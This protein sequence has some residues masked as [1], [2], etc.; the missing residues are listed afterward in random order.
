MM[1]QRHCLF[2]I[3]TIL[4]STTSMA[5]AQTAASKPLRE[6]RVLYVG[7]ERAESYV[8]F[9][10][11]HVEKIEAVSRSEFQPKQA[12]SFDVVLLDWPQGEETLE[13]HK[14][15]SPLGARVDWNRPTVLL[16]SA[17]LNL[18]VAWKLQ[19]GAGCTCMDPIAYGFRDH[20]IFR[21]PKKIQLD[22]QIRIP[23]P[24]AFKVDLSE[25][26]VDVL[27]L[28]DEYKKSWNAGW[29][30]Y[31]NYFDKNP[32]VEF[33]CGGVN[34]KTPTA[35]GL[36]RQGNLLHFGFEQSPQEMNA[37]GRDLLLNSIAYISRFSQD[38][39]IAI[40]PSVFGGEVAKPRR[41]PGAWLKYENRTKWVL[42]I[43]QPEARK[44][45]ESFET[46]EAMM[47]W[48]N[49]NSKYFAPGPD[50]LLGIDEDLKAIG[51]AFD[52]PE[53]FEHVIGDLNSNDSKVIERSRR[54]LG[55][56]V[57]CGPG[58]QADS[59]EWQSWYVT[60]QPYLFG[61]DTGDYQWYVDE[62]AK[63]RSK[64]SADFRGPLRA[65]Q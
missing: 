57:P 1:F 34:H 9:L 65:D 14:L 43:F 53:F 19:G 26:E 35:A 25:K 38:R 21:H 8:S 7:N 24:E 46:R 37:H 58:F 27:P 50:R 64:P 47:D 22:A 30:T 44:V 36:W 45:L 41:T 5:V 11:E 63:S 32:D 33:F 20:E 28:V 52:A 40:T 51:C 56:Y 23:T 10:E 3:A 2:A 49:Q 15:K 18:A 48:C 12:S 59:K 54:L 6:M 62:L 4:A 55:R 60:N 31:S 39:P 13:M 61:L 42:D 16:G 29:C 17:G